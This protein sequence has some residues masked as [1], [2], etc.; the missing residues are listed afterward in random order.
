MLAKFVDEKF[1]KWAK[2]LCCIFGM[3]ACVYRVFL[4]IDDSIAKKE[5]KNTKALIVGIVCFV[6]A[7]LGFIL[8]IIDMIS[9][10]GKN[11]FSG[12]LR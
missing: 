3:A 7:P 5:E 4:F 10:I 6:L 8:S 2:I 11:E 1:P 9:I 12:L